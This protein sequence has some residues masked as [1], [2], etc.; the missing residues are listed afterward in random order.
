MMHMVAV[1]DE[2]ILIYV[3]EPISRLYKTSSY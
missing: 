1:G 2:M 3:K